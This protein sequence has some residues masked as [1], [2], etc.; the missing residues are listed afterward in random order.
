[1]MRKVLI[2]G[3]SGQ[4][5]TILGDLYASESVQVVLVGRNFKW[6]NFDGIAN[7]KKLKMDLTETDINQ[8]LYNEKPDLIIYAAAFH[9]AAGIVYEQSI[10]ESY[11][12][13]VQVPVEI[14][15]YC[16]SNLH[17]QFAF[18]NSS[19]VFNFERESLISEKSIRSPDCVYSLQKEL[20][21]KAI[22]YYRKEFG[23]NVYN[24]WLFNHESEYREASYFIPRVISILRSSVKDPSFKSEINSLNFYCDWGVAKDYMS[25]IKQILWISKPDDFILASGNTMTGRELVTNLFGH[26]RLDSQNHIIEREPNELLESSR[27]RVNT[28]KFRKFYRGQMK[29]I[30]DF[31][32]EK[33]T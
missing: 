28:Q 24:F 17:V 30:G 5:G 25:A 19:K 3:G 27:W 4:D 23:V 33:V 32:L 12:I 18:F 2:F 16:R 8:F 14:L 26:F 6:K 7:V 9:G 21:Y 22:C 10:H 11:I 29:N 15:K 20:R 31:C 13:N 1:M